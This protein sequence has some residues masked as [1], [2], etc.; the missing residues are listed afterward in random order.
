MIE[1]IKGKSAQNTN[2]TFTGWG[3]PHCLEGNSPQ[4]LMKIPTG[5]L[6]ETKKTSYKIHSA[7]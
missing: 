7:K 3:P 2:A 4:M 5:S 1:R 6:A